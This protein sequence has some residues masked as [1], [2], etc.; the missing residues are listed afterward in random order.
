MQLSM[1][2]YARNV[3]GLKEANSVEFNEHT[4]DPI[5]YLIDEFIDKNYQMKSFRKLLIKIVNL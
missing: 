1:V 2:E 4:P 5:I 3:L